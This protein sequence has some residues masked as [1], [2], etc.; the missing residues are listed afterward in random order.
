M[1]HTMDNH[2]GR[3][4]M[5]VGPASY[6]AV[7]AAFD[8]ARLTQARRLAGMTKKAVADALGVSPVAVGQWEAGTHPPRPDHVGGLSDS[9][10]VPAAFFAAGRP[11]ARLES[12]AAHFRS[13]RKTPAI[14]R[15]KAIAFTEQVWELVYALEKRVQL[16]VVDLPGFSAGEVN[17]DDMPPAPAAAA[18]E[19][20]RR[21]SLGADR[22]PQLVRT[23]ERH[24][25]VV[26]LTP[27]A[28]SATENVDAFS[29]SHLPRPVVVL[30]PDRANDVYR[31]R[32]TA[33]HELGHLLLHPDA[34]PGDPLQEREADAFAAE[35][36]TPA[37]VITP[38]L[39]TRMDLHALDRLSKEWGVAVESLIYRCREVG[40][41]SEPAYR[42]AFQRLNQLRQLNL[43]GAEPISGYLGEIPT[44]LRR[45]FELAEA[46]GLSLRDLAD[47]LKI[48][49]PRLR[50]LLGQA[51]PRPHLQ[52]V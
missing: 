22:I 52:L 37:A 13:L 44:L 12:S 38:L 11:Y 4:V 19:L 33:A 3:H 49:L 29:T 27:F 1:S 35:L 25:I 14:Q 23:M 21:W 6:A 32:F 17:E 9:L 8:P 46:N 7:A 41:I 15:A 47:E 48:K 36:L 31:H 26:T 45:A 5:S 34:A 40:V 2:S 42:R 18:Q 43:F 24:G 50:L 51:D 39:P 28:G 16:P 10:T 20:R 30:T